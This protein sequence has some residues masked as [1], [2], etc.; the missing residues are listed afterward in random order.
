M[1]PLIDEMIDETPVTVYVYGE[2]RE[3]PK[4]AA[5]YIADLLK[6]RYRLYQDL[7]AL[8]TVFPAPPSP[9]TDPLR[10]GIRSLTE[11]DRGA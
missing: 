4:F 7:D 10:L 11:A 6:E 9:Q 3:I 1:S 5:D 8:R 2:P